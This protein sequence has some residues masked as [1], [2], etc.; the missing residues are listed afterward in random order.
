MECAGKPQTF[1]LAL[2]AARTSGR[3]V[4]VGLY[5]E[6]VSFD[7]NAII[8]KTLNVISSFGRPHAQPFGEKGPVELIADGTVRVD[9]L[10]THRFGLDRIN[11]AFEQQLSAAD[12]VKVLVVP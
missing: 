4:L 1:N 12:T 8:H 11:E 2:D 10:I 9:P 3:V 5:E 7:P 6:P